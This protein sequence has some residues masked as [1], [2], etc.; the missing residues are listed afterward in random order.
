MD[1]SSPIAEQGKTKAGMAAMPSAAADGVVAALPAFNNDR[2][3]PGSSMLVQLFTIDL[4]SSLRVLAQG[5]RHA[6]V[7]CT[8][9][10]HHTATVHH[11]KGSTHMRCQPAAP[12]TKFDNEWCTL[13]CFTPGFINLPIVVEQ[14]LL[15]LPGRDECSLFAAS[16]S[17]HTGYEASTVRRLFAAKVGEQAGP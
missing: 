6:N 14:S 16:G 12:R 10:W 17:G 5:N 1:A 15:C 3:L 4:K 2:G 8:G 7:P 13:D 11:T 9:A